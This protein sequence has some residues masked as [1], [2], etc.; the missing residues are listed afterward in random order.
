MGSPLLSPVEVQAVVEN[1]R[2]QILAAIAQPGQVPY[3]P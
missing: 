2:D 3:A 1:W